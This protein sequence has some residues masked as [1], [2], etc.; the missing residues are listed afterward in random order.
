MEFRIWMAFVKRK[1]ETGEVTLLFLMISA[2]LR[3]I[4]DAN[5]NTH[6]M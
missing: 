1:V 4:K 2:A 6:S 5:V 3:L